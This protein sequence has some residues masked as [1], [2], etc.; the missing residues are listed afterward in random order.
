ML[1]LYI[2]HG[3]RSIDICSAL[4]YKVKSNMI[5]NF[6]RNLIHESRSL[7]I[8]KTL[9]LKPHIYPVAYTHRRDAMFQRDY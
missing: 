8:S 3:M 7:M 2:V 6:K 4:I 9:K 5:I 1:L